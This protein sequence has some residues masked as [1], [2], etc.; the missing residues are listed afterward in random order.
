MA[1]ANVV[2]ERITMSQRQ[3]LYLL[4]HAKAVPW[5]P[6]I[7]DF[8]RSLS[9]RG[10]SHMAA[11]S[12]WVQRELAPPGAVLCSP[13]ARTRETLEPLLDTWPI[14]DPAVVYLPQIYEASTAMLFELASDAFQ[15]ADIVLMVGHNPGFEL[16]ALDVMRSSDAGPIHK[17]PTG[18]LAVID[19]ERGWSLDAG[20]GGLRHWIRR[21][22]LHRD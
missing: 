7:D 1:S 20:Q 17:M 18:T 16:L 6:G 9:Q 8:S 14:S 19:F 15:A 11:L 5:L 4:R 13:S 22:D 21:R 3:T 12:G 2:R 10:R